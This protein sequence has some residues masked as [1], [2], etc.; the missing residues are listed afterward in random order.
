MNPKRLE[1]YNQILTGYRTLITCL[2]TRLVPYFLE[3]GGQQHYTTLNLIGSV[4][5]HF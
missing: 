4:R 3:V 1:L 5:T 2:N